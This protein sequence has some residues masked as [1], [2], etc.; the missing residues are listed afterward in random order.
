MTFYNTDP[1]HQI[2]VVH[3]FNLEIVSNFVKA[4]SFVYNRK[5]ILA[6]STFGNRI[7]DMDS[8]SGFGN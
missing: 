2:T 8:E 4:K 5:R 3:K 6:G 1:D 7:R